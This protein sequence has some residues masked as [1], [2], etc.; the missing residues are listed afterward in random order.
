MNGLVISHRPGPESPGRIAL[1]I[2]HSLVGSV[3]F[4][5][6]EKNLGTSD[7][8]KGCESALHGYDKT[9]GLAGN[10]CAHSLPDVSH[11][12]GS[13]VWTPTVNLIAQNRDPVERL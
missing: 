12:T 7:R 13:V 2:I 11:A 6:T 10:N 3:H 5:F 9:P 1:P 4:D 8:I